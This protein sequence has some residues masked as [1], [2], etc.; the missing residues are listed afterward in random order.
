MKLNEDQLLFMKNKQYLIN[1]TIDERIDAI[2][3]AVEK[4]EKD[5]HE[6]GFAERCKKW[7][8]EKYISLSTPQLANVGRDYSNRTPLLPCSCNIIGVGNSIDSIYKGAYE[9]AMLSKLGAGVGA[10][11]KKVFDGGTELRDGFKTNSKL[12]WIED[13]VEVGKKVSQGSTRR[14]YI[15]PYESIESGEFWNLMDRID[16]NNPNKKDPLLNNTCGIILESGFFDRLRDSDE[17]K[18]R[19]LYIIQE[20][21]LTGKIYLLNEDNCNKNQSPVY[22]KL[23]HSVNSSNICCEALTPNYSDMTFACMLLSLNLSNWDIIKE[24]KQIIKDAFILLDIF[25]QMYIDLGESINGIERAVKSATDKRDIGL[26]TLGFHDYLQSKMFSMGG[27]DS[28]RVNREIY[29]TIR[30]V[31]EEYTK[32]FG[33][34]LGSPKLCQDAGLVRRNV[35]LM[36]VAPNKSTAFFMGT[37]E[38]VN[39]YT[40]NYNTSELAGINTVFKNRHLKKLLAEKGKDNYDVWSSILD[41]IGSVQHLDFLTYDEKSVFKTA[42]EISPKDM[43][44]LASDRQVYIDMGQSLNLWGRPNYTDVDVYNIHKY[45]WSKDIKTLYYMYPQ[46]HAV[47]EK[48]GGSWDSCESCAD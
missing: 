32:E 22:V 21:R 9:A 1:E 31:G 38:G 4:Y 13:Y 10:N 40:N 23:G 16:K 47:I 29:K 37:S 11:F 8:N 35:S 12:D 18:K 42:S 5:Y 44:D 39:P 36:M 45:A 15:T 34:R 20:R 30:E 19:Y 33:E 14:G 41:N 6:V 2:F 28:R 27:L 26:G 25:V 46:A 7:V 24:N 43:I 17:L 3:K 48:Q